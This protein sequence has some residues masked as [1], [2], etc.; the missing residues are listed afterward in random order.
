MVN[1]P[2]KVAAKHVVK[3]KRRL[4][5]RDWFFF[6]VWAIRLKKILNGVYSKE[7]MENFL[8]FNPRYKE[9]F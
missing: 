3:R 6:V 2:D 9:V 4:I 8:L 7:T 5:V 1:V